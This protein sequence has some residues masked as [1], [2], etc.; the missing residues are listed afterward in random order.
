MDR[1]I[2]RLIDVMY[3][4]VYVYVCVCLCIYK[5]LCV[6]E[7]AGAGSESSEVRDND[8]VLQRRRATQ[9]PPNRWYFSFFIRVFL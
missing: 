4:Y 7:R 2:D 8:L 9:R 3:V 5:T 6:C 1:S